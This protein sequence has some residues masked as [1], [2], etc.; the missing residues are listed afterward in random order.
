MAKAIQFFYG[1]DSQGRNVDVAQRVDGVWF[2]RW[3]VET[4]YGVQK[5]KWT[6]HKEPE[7]ETHYTNVYDGKCYEY[8]EPQMSWG[9]KTLKKLDYKGARLPNTNMREEKL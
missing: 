6:E 3:D 4:I 7:F 5:C 1:N 8:S 9:F 2:A